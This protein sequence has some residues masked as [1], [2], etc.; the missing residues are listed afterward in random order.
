M[1]IITLI[2]YSRYNRTLFNNVKKR[3]LE[4]KESNKNTKS[5]YNYSKSDH[6]AREYF[7]NKVY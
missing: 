3:T 6:F 2:D 4:V 5:Y 1:S 7:L